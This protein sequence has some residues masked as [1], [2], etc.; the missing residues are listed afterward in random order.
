[1]MTFLRFCSDG[2]DSTYP[3]LICKRLLIDSLYIAWMNRN[4]GTGIVLYVK[5]LSKAKLM[6]HIIYKEW[7]WGYFRTMFNFFNNI[8]NR[9]SRYKYCFQNI[10]KRMSLKLVLGIKKIFT[11][12]WLTS[13]I[14]VFVYECKLIHIAMYVVYFM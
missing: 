14:T 11:E 7:A 13:L 4:E 3:F 2:H 6:R 5:K 10:Y 9:R 8:E 12:T 1:M